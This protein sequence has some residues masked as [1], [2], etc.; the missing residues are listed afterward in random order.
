LL[1]G[2]DKRLADKTNLP[3][4]VA[5]DPLKAVVRGTGILL[6]NLDEYRYLMD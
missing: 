4:H 5:E 2:L 1:R 3:I 6:K